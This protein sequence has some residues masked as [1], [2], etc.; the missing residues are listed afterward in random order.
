MLL[1]CF[2]SSLLLLTSYNPNHKCHNSL[3]QED[4]VR[5]VQVKQNQL[6]AIILFIRNSIKMIHAWSNYDRKHG[7]IQICYIFRFSGQ[8]N[9]GTLRFVYSLPGCVLKVLG[10]DKAYCGPVVLREHVVLFQETNCKATSA[11]RLS[12]MQANASYNESE[13]GKKDKFLGLV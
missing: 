11:A 5:L 6:T 7:F 1:L 13:A 3:T 4:N 9:D 12:K 10:C 8:E 2:F